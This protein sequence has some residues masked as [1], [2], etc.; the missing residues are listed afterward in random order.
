MPRT[1]IIRFL[2]TA[3]AGGAYT[4]TVEPAT[5]ART[6][7]S[8]GLFADRRLE[9]TPATL[10]LTGQTVSLFHDFKLEV[11]PKTLQ[12]TGLT[13]TMTVTAAPGVYNL[14]VLPG[15]LSLTGQSIGLLKTS[16]L[17][18]T[19]ATL[20]LTG[21]S[22][23]L[24]RGFRLEVAP[25][26]LALTGQTLEIYYNRN[27]TVT[28]ATLQLTGLSVTMTKGSSAVTGNICDLESCVLES[29]AFGDITW[30]AAMR[31]LLAAA[32]GQLSAPPYGTAGTATVKNP[33]GTKTRIVASVDERGG[34]TA[35]TTLDGS[36]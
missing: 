19:P 12:L 3:S 33:D 30:G 14:E 7:Q 27:L 20:S 25:A 2:G 9:V 15:T 21:Q 10:Q 24:Y 34:R 35:I 28:P 29:T 4:L 1:P 31:I 17:E 26:T 8:I 23:G 11:T 18:V 6:G 36:T 13:V 32:A 16:R 5:L 22:I